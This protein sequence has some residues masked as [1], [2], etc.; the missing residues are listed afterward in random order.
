VRGYRL[1]DLQPVSHGNAWS[2]YFRDP[3]GNRIE[4]YAGSPWYVSQPCRMPF[5]PALGA[6]EIFA[7]TEAWCRAQ[8]G[9]AMAESYQWAL[10]ERISAAKA[11][12]VAGR[13]GA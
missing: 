3:E 7:R 5:D 8:P 12:S 4:V 6:D 11:R 9:F 10:A 13:A 1:E 2:I